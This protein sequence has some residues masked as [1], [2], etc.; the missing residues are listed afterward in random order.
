MNVE[1]DGF[2]N[3]AASDH[4]TGLAMSGDTR[5]LPPGTVLLDYTIERTL[6]YG[7]FGI[8]YLA[9]CDRARCKLASDGLCRNSP[10]K[11]AIKEYFP[12]E[13]AY[14]GQGD[15][16][17]PAAGEDEQETFVWG[18]DRFRDEATTLAQLDYPNVVEIKRFFSANGTAYLVMPFYDGQTL[19]QRVKSGG[20]LPPD[21]VEAVFRKLVQALGQVHAR[22]LLHRDIK[23]ANVFITSQGEP[24]LIDFGAARTA[25]G[26]HSKTITSILTPGY[27]AYE[28]HSTQGSQ[29]GPWTDI[30][31]LAATMY[32]AA[33][34]IRPPDSFDR[35]L[36]DTLVPLR[37]AAGPEFARHGQLLA[38]IDAGLRVRPAQRPRS[39]EDWLTIGARPRQGPG[40]GTNT[41]RIVAIVIG[42]LFFMLVLLAIL[43]SQSSPQASDAVVEAASDG[44]TNPA[45]AAADAAP[46]SAAPTDQGPATTTAE[47]PTQS[48]ADSNVDNAV[49][50]AV[51]AAKRAEPAMTRASQRPD[52][53]PASIGD[54]NNPWDNCYASFRFTDGSVYRGEWHRDHAVGS[55]VKVTANG[56]I[57][58]GD[59][60]DTNA[61]TYGEI[62]YP[63]KYVYLGELSDVLAHGWG[64][65][66]DQA[67]TI[68]YR[69]HFT[70]GKPDN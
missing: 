68:V 11:V 26:E 56:I 52:C 53:G 2:A 10:C 34:R 50:L 46:A 69:G 4:A 33:T 32:F 64:I 59:F 51:N 37:Q 70:N 43:G 41:A 13:F 17:L 27:G 14:R 67:G 5:A 40:P 20:P 36:N 44:A 19:D 29:Q 39:V 38:M 31:G 6:G 55:G 66:K 22:R 3:D 23:P 9:A 16:V 48:A 8:T 54:T 62:V 60:T 28:Q 30:Y 58:A 63:N 18:L 45:L 15:T 47:V 42:A 49:N 57:V 65:M 12:R 25:I 24:I 1:G 7:G 61:T 35:D 21:L